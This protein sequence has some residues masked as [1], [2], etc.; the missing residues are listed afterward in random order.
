MMSNNSIALK[1]I[2]VE[3]SPIVVDRVQ[4]LLNEIS[5]T[6]FKGNATNIS[7]ALNLIKVEQPDVVILDISLEEDKP[8]ASGINLLIDIRKKYPDLIIIMFTNLSE[9]QYRNSCMALGAN[10]FFDKSNEFEKITEVLEEVIKNRE[11]VKKLAL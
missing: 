11:Q 8:R 3:D 6:E 4:S 10:Y 1:I 9:P 7:S 2:T 5:S